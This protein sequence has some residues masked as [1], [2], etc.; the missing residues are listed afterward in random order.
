MRGRRSRRISL[1][2]R[3]RYR[4]GKTREFRLNLLYHS[5]H[6]Q[7]SKMKRMVKKGAAEYYAAVQRKADKIVDL[8]KVKIPMG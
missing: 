6:F 2:P 5:F 8:F 7:I 4:G 3:I 1:T